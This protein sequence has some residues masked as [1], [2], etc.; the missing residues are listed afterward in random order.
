MTWA[1]AEPPALPPPGLVDRLRLAWRTPL[2]VAWLGL[3]F[4]AFLACRGADL[5]ARRVAGRRLPALAPWLVVIWARGAL[6]LLGLRQEVRGTAMAHPGALVANHSSWLD[7]V[8]LQ[9]ATRVFFVS[10]AEV[11]GWPV[12]G[13]IGRAIG[14]MFIERR[15]TEAGRQTAA[16]H[17]RI[18]RGDRLVIFPEGTSSDGGRV[19]PF[20]TALFAVFFAPDL[21]GTLWVQP[22]TL[23]YRPRPDLP[24]TLYGWWGGMDFGGHLTKLLM[25]SSGGKVEIDFHPPLRAADFADRKPLAAAAEARVRDG[26]A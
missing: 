24:P 18:A 23:R 9:A 19:L 17:A 11:A 1:E 25:R 7:I 6:A 3:C 8:A 14:T 20:K 15:A 10:K 4:A 5:L 2:A 16:L 22:V 21:H 13:A 12:I 26:L